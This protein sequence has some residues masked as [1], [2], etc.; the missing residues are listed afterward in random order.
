MDTLTSMSIF[1]R[2]VEI[3]SFSAVANELGMS[4]PSVSKHLS[5]LEAHLGIRLLNRNTRHQ[6]LTDAGK[7]YYDYCVRILLDI[8]EAEAMVSESQGQPKGTLKLATP[9]SYGQKVIAPMLWT[10]MQKYPELNIDL[11]LDDRNIDLIKEGI[12][13]AIRLGPLNDSSLVARSLDTCPRYTVASPDY[14]KKMGTP[15][16]LDDLKQHNCI[17]FTLFPTR[18]EWH[19]T[20]NNRDK[21]VHVTGRLSTNNPTT[22]LSASIAH[23]GISVMPLFMIK[24]SLKNGVL[25]TIL[26]DYQPIP[27][28]IN[29]IYPV[30][31]F[32]PQK[33]KCFIEHYQQHEDLS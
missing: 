16:T 18:N 7:E 28:P 10:F 12:D 32:V 13:L 30:R 14:L 21:Q 17:V 23:Q 26:N 11:V 6:T 24:E 29:A 2:V 4:Q 3:G 31:R 5:S 9:I 33:V 19:F 8:S 1:R 22:M 20:H 15:K 25:V 27:I